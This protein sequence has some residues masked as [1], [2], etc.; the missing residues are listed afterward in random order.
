MVIIFNEFISWFSL[1]CNVSFPTDI[2]ALLNR[3]LA[4]VTSSEEDQTEQDNKPIFY[5]EL[6]NMQPFRPNSYWFLKTG[7]Y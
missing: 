6:W 4:T 3:V 5:K 2:I 7:K 1:V